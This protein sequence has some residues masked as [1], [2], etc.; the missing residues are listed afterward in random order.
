MA[1]NRV[2]Y[3]CLIRLWIWSYIHFINL[4]NNNNIIAMLSY[5]ALFFTNYTE[6][7]GFLFFAN[8][9][10]S[11]KF[12]LIFFLISPPPTE[13]INIASFF[14]KFDIFNQ[15]T[16]L[17]SQPSSLILAVSSET[18]SKGVYDSIWQI[19]LKSLT[20]WE[21]FPALPPTPRK[22]ILPFFISLIFFIDKTNFKI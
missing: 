6:N 8:F 21:E 3:N 19:F 13:N 22:K 7:F 2:P 12:T 11:I 20:A 15:F 9:A 14:D 1:Y 16:K 10:A 5:I 18:L 4:R 17:V